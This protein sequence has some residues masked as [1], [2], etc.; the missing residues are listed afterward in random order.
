M[1][2]LITIDE[3]LLLWI[4]KRA[5][6]DGWNFFWIAVTSLGNAGI[7]WLALSIYLGS[8]LWPYSQYAGF[9]LLL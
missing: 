4:Q 5:R 6:Y 8:S 2:F 7:V 1:G 3:N 9:F